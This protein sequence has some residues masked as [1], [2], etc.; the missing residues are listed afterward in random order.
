MRMIVVLCSNRKIFQMP[1]TFDGARVSANDDKLSG[2]VKAGVSLASV[3]SSP[4]L[5]Q[6]ID[7]TART[8]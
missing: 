5:A 7:H 6:A 4:P 2:P 8:H 1:N 3:G